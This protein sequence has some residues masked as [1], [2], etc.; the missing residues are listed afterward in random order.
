MLRLKRKLALTK[1]AQGDSTACF[2]L[3]KSVWIDLKLGDLDTTKRSPN[4]LDLLKALSS[5]QLS[6]SSRTRVSRLEPDQREE[7]SAICAE[8]QRLLFFLRPAGWVQ[9]AV[10]VALAQRQIKPAVDDPLSAA[11]SAFSG[12]YLCLRLPSGWQ[13]HSLRY[14]DTAIEKLKLA[15]QSFQR[16]DLQRDLAYLYHVAGRPER[17]LELLQELS[18]QGEQLGHLTS[19]PSAYSLSATAMITM[20]EFESAVDVGWKGYHL[21]QALENRRDLILGTCQLIRAMLYLGQWEELRPLYESLSDADFEQFPYLRV[22][23]LQLKVEME[24]WEGLPGGMERAE[25]CALEGIA[26][27]ADLDELRYYRASL[28]VLLIESRL[29]GSVGSDAMTAADWDDS[30]RHLRPFSH[31]RFRLK[32][33]KMIWHLKLGEVDEARLSAQRLMERPECNSFRRALIKRHLSER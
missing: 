1:D 4:L 12:A 29:K 25:A 7:M 8:L 11:Q 9:Q 28:H 17:S 16:L 32:L 20:A 21:A 5:R 33:M 26:L 15:P 18:T 19:L 23:W 13:A 2:A 27:C 22:T 3:L 14:L 10:E 30:E 6:L 31:L 24:I